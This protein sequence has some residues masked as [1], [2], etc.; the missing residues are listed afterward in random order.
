MYSFIIIPGKDAWIVRFYRN[1]QVMHH[2]RC[3]LR[4]TADAIRSTAQA[5]VDRWNSEVAA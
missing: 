5:V 1:G 4:E 3:E 2:W